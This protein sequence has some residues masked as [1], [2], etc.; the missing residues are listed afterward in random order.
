[1]ILHTLKV[2]GWKCFGDWFELGPFAEGITVVSGPNGS[3]KSSLFW[4]LARALFDR[5]G[6]GGR[7]MDRLRSWDR[8]LSPEVS[9]DFEVDGAAWRVEKT[10]LTGALCRL[11]RLDGG[12]AT[13][14]AE[15]EAADEHLRSLLGFRRATRG[16]S[17]PEHWGLAQ[18]LWAPQ[19]TLELPALGA[20]V[21]G[22]IQQSLGGQL[23]AGS[24]ISGAVEG[25]FLRYYSPTG[26]ELRGDRAPAVAALRDTREVLRAQRAELDAQLLE[27]EELQQELELC[28]A[29]NELLQREADVERGNLEKEEARVREYQD[30]D[31]EARLGAKSAEA[32]EGQFRSLDE[33]IRRITQHLGR[34]ATVEGELPAQR[35]ALT[36]ARRAMEESGRGEAAAR[37]ALEALRLSS[38]AVQ[39]LQRR[40]S[41]ARDLRDALREAAD[42]E[43][44][45]A[46]V[47][48]KVAEVG[49]LRDERNV[50]LAPTSRELDGIRGLQERIRADRVR[51]EAALITLEFVPERDLAAEVFV[52]DAPGS[53]A[54]RE[55]MPAVV[56]GAPVVEVRLAGIGRIRASGP[57]GDVETLRREIGEMEEDLAGRTRGFGT[58]EVEEL[59]RRVARAVRLD[60][61]IRAAEEAKTG[62]LRGESSDALV[63]TLA[64][65][66]ER[67]RSVLDGFP[68]W[69]QASPDVDAAEQDAHQLQDAW[70]REVREAEG[71]LDLARA[72]TSTAKEDQDRADGIV[73]TAVGRLEEDR[74]E[75]VALRA[76]DGLDDE[77]RVRRRDR[78]ALDHHAAAAR[79]ARARE[80]LADFGEDPTPT[81]DRLRETVRDYQD[82]VRDRELRINSLQVRLAGMVGS[83]SPQL[84][85]ARTEETLAELDARIQREERRMDAVQLLRRLVLEEEQRRMDSLVAPVE[86]DAGELLRRISGPRLGEL[87]IGEGLQPAHLRPRGVRVGVEPGIED[88]S[89]GEQEQVHFAVRLALAGL[90]AQD[91]RQLVVLDDV[92]AYTDLGRTKHVLGI[93][94]ELSQ[95]LQIVI[96]TCHPERYGSL[97]ARHFDLETLRG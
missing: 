63:Q 61:S 67:I 24:C 79:L 97:A 37:E 10:F 12:K 50:L 15:G 49:Q 71:A 36:A 57:V 9:V 31:A 22:V 47:Q 86:R 45:L 62:L 77:E 18:L 73:A 75:I 2:K 44:R 91:A 55:G 7:E 16:L 74:E 48:A 89:G 21:L 81:R 33:R 87:V 69:E 19:G 83:R 13:L 53:L 3:G 43:E 66:R 80:R 25:E 95:R 5:H 8:D 56:R 14:Y 84:E 29:R 85:L 32:A 40:A 92:L 51:L 6:A 41:A 68:E 38:E 96:L 1:M 34:I 52:G 78:A 58:G 20:E 93:L 4:A 11:S 82:G 70:V 35:E 88:L 26:R 30:L 90:L 17:K 39:R 60:D 28:T 72:R 59:A 65:C 76:A 23:A 64:A 94:E 42:A 54:L 27:F 46:G